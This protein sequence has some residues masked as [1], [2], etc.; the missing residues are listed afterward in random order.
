[1]ADEAFG[2]CSISRLK[3]ASPLE[4]DV[5][6]TTEVHVGGRVKAQT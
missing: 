6:C 1:L 5:R 2:V 4:L 3:D